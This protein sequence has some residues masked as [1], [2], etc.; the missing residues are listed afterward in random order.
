MAREAD[1]VFSSPWVFMIGSHNT[2]TQD[3]RVR[4]MN[5]V[6][7]PVVVVVVGVGVALGVWLGLRFTRAG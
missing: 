6:P 4:Q 7:W 2:V 3:A 5:G 1:T